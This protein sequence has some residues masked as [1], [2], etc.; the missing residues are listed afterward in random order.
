MFTHEEYASILAK[1]TAEIEKLGRLKGNEYSGDQDRLL[2]F[3]RNGESQQ[4]PMETIWS[5]YASKHWDAIQ[6]YVLDQRNGKARE[7]LE[8]LEGRCDDLIVYLILFKCMLI[9][10]NR[11]A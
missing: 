11:Q 7:R 4:L 1:T 5:I 10:R 9:E 2:N 3:R 6:Q 8:S